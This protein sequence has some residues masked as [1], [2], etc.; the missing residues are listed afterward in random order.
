MN[1]VER[2]LQ[3]VIK[4]FEIKDQKKFEGYQK[5][6]EKFDEM[7]KK[8]ITKRRGNRIDSM[9]DRAPN[10]ICFNTSQR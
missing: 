3:N 1:N 2:K 4:S 6:S 5:A 10:H 7:V 9:S 8:G